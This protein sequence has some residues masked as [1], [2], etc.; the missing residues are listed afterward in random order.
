MTYMNFI[1]GIG[2]LFP[3]QSKII[4]MGVNII[5]SGTSM[6]HLNT[7]RS[8]IVTVVACS[9]VLPLDWEW[10][11]VCLKDCLIKIQGENF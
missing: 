10:P 4:C 8:V 5:F 1:H 6:I 7:V 11:S 3:S 9:V 2:I